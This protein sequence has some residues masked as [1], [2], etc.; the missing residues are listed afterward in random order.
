MQAENTARKPGFACIALLS[1]DSIYWKGFNN[2]VARI[3]TI[4]DKPIVSQLIAN[5]RNNASTHDMTQATASAAE[6]APSTTEALY[7]A[8]CVSPALVGPGGIGGTLLPCINSAPANPRSRT[9]KAVDMT[10][11]KRRDQVIVY[12]AILFAIYLSG[13]TSGITEARQHGLK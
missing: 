2:Q 1:R 7:G 10:M 6:I 9:A 5:L 11:A 8:R 4:A 13:I 12:V 3:K